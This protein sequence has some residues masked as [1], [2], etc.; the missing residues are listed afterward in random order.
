MSTIYS[1]AMLNNIGVFVGSARE[2][3]GDV[4]ET[5]KQSSEINVFPS[6]NHV[7]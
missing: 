5:I 1:V 6:I 4:Q 2:M 7:I 3:G